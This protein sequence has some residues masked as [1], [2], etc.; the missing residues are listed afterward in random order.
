MEKKIKKKVFTFKKYDKQS[1]DPDIFRCGLLIN[2][3]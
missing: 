1:T 2:T 3:K